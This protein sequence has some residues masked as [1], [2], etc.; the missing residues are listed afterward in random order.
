MYF[1]HRSRTHVE[2]TAIFD[3]NGMRVVRAATT[4][5]PGQ[6]QR[7]Y[8]DPT[9]LLAVFRRRISTLDLEDNVQVKSTKAWNKEKTIAAELCNIVQDDRL[10]VSVMILLNDYSIDLSC[11]D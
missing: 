8:T 7:S 11:T 1:D 5:W 6:R 4:N 9:D 2:P 10:Q 3:P